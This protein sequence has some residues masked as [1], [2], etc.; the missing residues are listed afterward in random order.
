MA[1][2]ESAGTVDTGEVARF[3]ARID[4]TPVRTGKAGCELVIVSLI[5]VGIEK[6]LLPF[7][8]AENMGVMVYSP[9]LEFLRCYGAPGKAP[10]NLHLPGAE[11]ATVFRGARVF[12]VKCAISCSTIYAF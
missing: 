6:D 4:R 1:G 10:G 2:T 8:Q 3:A 11:V 9:Q 7:C 12:S 5:D